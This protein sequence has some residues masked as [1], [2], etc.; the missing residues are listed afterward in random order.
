MKNHGRESDQY[1]QVSR[2]LSLF[3]IWF[4]HKGWELPNSLIWLA[5][6]DIKTGLDYSIVTGNVLQWKS[7]KLKC[8][9]I[10]YFHLTIFFYGIAKNLAFYA[11]ALWAR[12]A[13]VLPHAYDW[14]SIDQ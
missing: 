11:D 8:K 10:D 14:L 2:S 6:I 12:H 7:C 9:I 5:E 3:V 1:L 4:S 13:I